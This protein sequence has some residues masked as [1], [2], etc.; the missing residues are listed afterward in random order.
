MLRLSER[1][2]LAVYP[3]V[4]SGYYRLKPYPNGFHNNKLDLLYT[5]H[6]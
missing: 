1:S 2:N 5:V 4:N 3:S 6:T